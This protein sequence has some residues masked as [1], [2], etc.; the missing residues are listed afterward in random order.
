M[1]HRDH[2]LARRT[3][4]VL[5]ALLFGSL[6]A[7]PP[8]AAYSGMLSSEDAGVTGTG[9]WIKTGPTTIEWIVTPGE[10]CAW[11]YAYTFTHPEGATS[12]F[13]LETSGNF[14]DVDI[15]GVSGDVSEVEIGMHHVGGA[16]PT[17]PEHVYGVK[18]GTDGLSTHIEFDSS[19]LPMWGD[20]YS[21]DGVAGG[22]GMNS[23]WNAGFTVDD[24]DPELPVQDGSIDCHILVPDTHYCPIEPSTWGAIK[25]MYR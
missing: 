16:N 4:F 7:S 1:N 13:I 8:A 3:L 5:T 21:K 22:A 24:A 17:M 2:A 11:H 20:F 12:H 25:N 9:Q 23:A 15:W 10:G 14:T 19:R 18:F 6:A